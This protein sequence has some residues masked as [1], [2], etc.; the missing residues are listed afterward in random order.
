MVVSTD[1][2]MNSERWQKVKNLFDAVVELA[3]GER[4]RFLDKSCGADKNLRRDVENLLASLDDAES[5][6]ESPAVG[7]FASLIVESKSL[8]AGKRFGHYEIVR[9]IGAGGMGEV[10]LALDKKLDRSVAVKI[11]NEKF[12]KHESNLQRFIKE[13]KAASALNHPNILVIH[14]IGES[15]N[16]NYIVS[17][18]IEGETL[19]DII[20]KTSL[21]L[22]EILEIAAQIANALVAAHTAKIVHRDIKPE[23]VIVRP[24][25]FVKILDF[26]LAKLVEQKIVGF[27][28]ETVKQNETAKGV[29]LGTVNYMSPEQAK[30]EQVD[31]R[32]DIFSFGVTLYEMIA[33]RT[34]FAGDSMS[35]TF[36]NLINSEPPPLAR[37]ADG[38][39]DEL[40]RIVAKTLRKKKDE[41][42]QTIKDLL[43]DLKDLRDNLAFDEKLERSHP[44]SV[45]NA[46]A[47]LQAATGDV[48][49]Q[50]NEENNN[51]TA[52]IKRHKSLAAFVLIILLIGTIGFGY[53]F[54]SVRKTTSSAAVKKSLAVLPFVNTSQDANAEYLSDGIT[55][56]VINNL[57][58]LSGLKV[59]S[60]N[61]AFRFKDNQTDT[62]NIASQLGVENLVTGDIRQIGDRLVINVRLIDGKD[63]SQTWGD[64]YVRTLSDVVTLQNEIARDVARKLG[65]R[66]SGAE[67]QKLAKNYTENAEAYQFYL[68]G[69]FLQY[70]ITPPDLFKS[71]EFYRQAIA[72]DPN[73]ALAYVG[74]A[75]STGR[76]RSF[77]DIPKQ[78]YMQMAREYALKAVS[79]DDRL[80]EARAT[81]GNILSMN[82]YDFA[83]AEREYQRALELNPNYAEAHLWRGQLFSSLGRHEEALAEIRRAI[84]LDPMSLEANSAYGEALF[85]ARRYDESIAHLKKVVNLDA[86]YFPAHRY[87]AFNYEMKG[88]YAARIAESVKINEITNSHER[89]EAMKNSFERGGW[90][91][92]LRDATADNSPLDLHGYLVVTFCA[93]LGDKDK[94]FAILEELYEERESEIVHIKVDPRLDNLR[95]EPRFVDLM[96]RMNFE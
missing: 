64:Q 96:R 24:D 9:Q 95:R 91:G 72:L 31:A 20:L 48:N 63:D 1:Y 83:G 93:E 53:Y 29:I 39:P 87:L 26:G 46:T 77:R 60:R 73:F 51:F 25:G 88:D 69:H 61:S 28:D 33:G 89:G 49:N 79:L 16:S 41:R 36:A 3:P 67:E 2:E 68:R 43:T 12:A 13:A 92:F 62:R 76:L 86:N 44:P 90:Q 7:E 15:E 5:F 45:E 11:L 59:M 35:E 27:D 71:I 74:L 34:P 66:L 94:A 75:E 32:T 38:V 42:Y 47:F 30:G 14:E 50:T 70:K 22:P 17:E 10:Y 82:D 55:E 56:S 4:G 52:Q 85:F 58:Q 37:L 57:S 18:Y 19:R 54:W 8:E 81:L 78:N 21:G 6:M 40:Q 23:N 80:P 65:T 84:E